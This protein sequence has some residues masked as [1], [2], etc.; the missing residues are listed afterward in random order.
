LSPRSCC[1]SWLMPAMACCRVSSCTNV[2]RW[3]SGQGGGRIGGGRETPPETCCC[4]VSRMPARLK[5][6]VAGQQGLHGLHTLPHPN[7]ASAVPH[8]A[9]LECD[10]AAGP[11]FP[12]TKPVLLHMGGQAGQHHPPCSLCLPPAAGGWLPAPQ[13]RRAPAVRQ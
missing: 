4:Q 12:N 9:T 11:P 13:L 1:S 6:Y 3:G 7:A 5:L 10:A 8:C 2:G